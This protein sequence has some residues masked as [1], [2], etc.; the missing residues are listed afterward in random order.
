MSGSAA[1]DGALTCTSATPLS[2]YQVTADPVSPEISGSRYF[3]SNS[4]GV[5]YEDQ[6]S[7]SGNMPEAGAPAHG[8]EIK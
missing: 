8:Q 5:I 4:Q 2:G 1:E 6:G 3:G 7:F